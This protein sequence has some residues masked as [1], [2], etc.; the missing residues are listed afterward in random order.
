MRKRFSKYMLQSVAGMIGI[1]IY[2]LADTFFISVYA[3]AD[4]LAVLNLILPV[5]G[6]IYAIGCLI[7]IGSATRY[8]ITK[9]R[10]DKADFYFLQA[11]AWSVLISIPFVLTGI[12]APD[13]LMHLLGADAGLTQLGYNYIRIILIASPFFISNY[14]FTAFARND[15]APMT[16]MLGSIAGSMFNIIFDYVFMFPMHLGL[17]GAALA[18]AFCPIVTMSV[19][20]THYFSKRNHVPFHWRRLSLKRFIPCCQLGIS[21]FVGEFSNGIIAIVFNMLLLHIAGNI[22]VAAYGIIANL[23]VVAMSIFNGLAQGAQPLI[24]ESYGKGDSAQVKQLAR[25]SICTC[26][27]VELAVVICIW[28]FTDPLIAIFNSEN[29]MQFLQYAHTGLRLYFLGFLFAGIN[30]MLVAYFS[31]VDNICPAVVG[32]IL[33]GAVAI[34]LCALIFSMLFGINGVW[35]SFLGS[36]II[37]FVVVTLLSRKKEARL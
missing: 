24:S 23:S 35:T 20:C 15:N 25:W 19:C 7:G 5:Y 29:N 3:G 14:S 34:V 30:I 6:L 10:G 31:A 22:G 17:P 11:I 8:S 21:A 36:E 27:A 13:K 26:M 33:R 4:G 16:A 1:S 37:T 18:T 12:L 32:S 28:V 2:V 9:A